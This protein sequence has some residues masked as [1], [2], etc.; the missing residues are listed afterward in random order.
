MRQF[1]T[2]DRNV[3]DN[4]EEKYNQVGENVSS[5]E[6]ESTRHKV[7]LFNEKCINDCDVPELTGRQT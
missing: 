3:Y 5:R 6:R 1:L 4:V 2:T 7:I